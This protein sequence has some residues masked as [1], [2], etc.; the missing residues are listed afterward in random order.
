MSLNVLPCKTRW[1]AFWIVLYLNGFSLKYSPCLISCI[2]MMCRIVILKICHHSR[3]S[4]YASESKC[5][6]MTNSC[7]N[8]INNNTR[9]GSTTTLNTLGPVN[10]GM[11][12]ENKYNFLLV[13]QWNWTLKPSDSGTYRSD[14]S[15]CGRCRTETELVR[16]SDSSSST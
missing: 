4:K 15:T 2:H 6:F 10:C 9:G 8:E 7:N 3:N 12:Q 16:T 14:S 1:I 5:S 11:N 13:Q